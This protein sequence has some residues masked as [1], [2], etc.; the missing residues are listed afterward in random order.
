MFFLAG[1]D[2]AAA[3]RAAVE[4]GA[5]LLPVEWSWEGVRTW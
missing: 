5:H 4:A 3:R 2:V 1:D